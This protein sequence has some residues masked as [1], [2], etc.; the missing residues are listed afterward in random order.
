M[1]VA[2]FRGFGEKVAAAAAALS[3]RMR[4]GRIVKRRFA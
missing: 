3:D 1:P 4:I 2:M